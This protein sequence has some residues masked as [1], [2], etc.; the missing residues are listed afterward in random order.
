MLYHVNS[1]RCAVYKLPH[2]DENLSTST[3]L[4]LQTVF[5]NLQTSDHEVTTKELTV[6]FGW[7]SAEAFLQQDVQEMMRVLIDKLEDKMKGTVVDGMTKQLFAGRVRSYI[8]C[9]NVQYESKREEDFYDI[10]LDVK[11]CRNI[12]HSFDKYI[13]VEML[14]GENQY[15]A[16]EHGK[17]DA[18]KGVIFETF[19]PVLTVHLKRF[20][21]DLQTMNFTKIHDHYEFPLRLELDRYVAESSLEESPRV[22][23]NYVL[24]SVLVHQGDVGG[25]HYYAYIRPTTDTFQYSTLA[26]PES[27]A[28]VAHKDRQWFKF[29][30]ETVS[31]V[32]QRE[33]VDI[34]YG[35]RFRDPNHLRG[36]SS[37]YMLVYIRETEAP[38]I[39]KPVTM[40]DIPRGL[41]ERLQMEL[42]AKRA[43]AKR[44]QRRNNMTCAAFATETEVAQFTHYS[45]N[46][47][48]LDAKL[49]KDLFV[50]KESSTLCVLLNIADRLHC[51]PVQ[52]RLWEIERDRVSFQLG[53][54]LT[55]DELHHRI[56][57]TSFYAESVPF[58]GSEEEFRDFEATY[59]LIRS[60]ESHYL[61][62][63]R[64]ELLSHEDL[65]YS[66]DEDPVAGCG[67]GSSNLP[68]AE[69]RQYSEEVFEKFNAYF[70]E[71]KNVML[72]HLKDFYQNCDTDQLLVFIKL[73]DPY[74]MLPQL[75]ADGDASLNSASEDEHDDGGGGDEQEEEDGPS[76]EEAR[77]GSGGTGKRRRT[78]GNHVP[79][80]QYMPMKY[81]GSVIVAVGDPVSSLALEIQNIIQEKYPSI[82]AGWQEECQKFG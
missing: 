52:I 41:E 14:D 42:D 62:L 61:D 16:G 13:E 27:L 20:D 72:E 37:A 1:F 81:L 8:K 73:Y 36:L 74:D 26:D 33:A 57:L 30:D 49:M 53:D 23:N 68:I 18:Q 77:G 55:W 79:V 17:Q 10:Q 2:E 75:G 66:E 43:I 5:R 59:Q 28:G 35:R 25:G 76:D 38:E 3:T 80:A 29:N 32:P 82:P 34:C 54:D 48:W 19:P 63:L 60:R 46:N 22:P 45:R 12:Y 50:L 47:D 51:N 44:L 69:L 21:F 11:G 56:K 24:H 70:L 4:A 58:C 15:E 6:A 39:M 71:L 65:F 7:T 9:V 67:I 64:A 78:L 31:Q 40:E